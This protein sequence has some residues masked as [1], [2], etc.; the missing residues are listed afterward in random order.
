M[1]NKKSVA[2]IGSTGSIGRQALDI[3]AQHPDIFSAEVL[4]ANTQADL[5]IEQALKFNPNVVVIAD[6]TQYQ[7]VKQALSQTDI[8]VFAGKE[9]IDE[10]VQMDCVDIVL[11]A[12][13]GF[14]GLSPTIK[15]IEKGKLIAL[16]NKETLVVAGEY[17]MRLAKQNN[18]A[19]LPVDSEHS[20]IFQCLIGEINNEV[21]KIYLTASGGP[22]RNLNAE[23]LSK[24]S[25][26]QALNH[27]NWAMGKKVT[28]DSATLMNK[29][30]EMIEARWLFDIK[31][32][33]IEAVI[34][35]QSIIHSMVEFEDGSIKAQLGVADMRLPIQYALNFPERL[36]NTSEKL[37]I[38]KHST[39]TFEKPNTELF[40]CLS[41]AYHAIEQGGNLPAIMNAANEVAVEAF[42]KEKIQFIQIPNIIEEA[43]NTFAFVKNPSLEDYFKTDE[44]VKGKLRKEILNN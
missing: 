23:E 13:V 30:F 34:H 10:V 16:A 25:V 28:I 14:A 18:T 35:P 20:A 3:I 27:P 39:L 12:L 40:P 19:I 6:K 43:F 21:N 36:P 29:G 24:V 31:P 4:T 5:L 37:D 15:A 41:L 17:V 8:K 26:A 33:K 42:L 11:M 9:S 32:S 7:K 44:L 1:M 22:F 38:F 2:V